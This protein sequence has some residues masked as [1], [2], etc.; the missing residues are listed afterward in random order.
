MS[1][2]NPPQIIFK[3]VPNAQSIKLRVRS[4]QLIQISYPKRT[5]QKAAQ[6]FLEKHQDFVV[7]RIA[8]I[9]VEKLAFFNRSSSA[10]NCGQLYFE[11]STS[12]RVAQIN[13][14]AE[15]LHILLPEQLDLTQVNHL[16]VQLIAPLKQLAKE[17]LTKRMLAHAQQNGYAIE[18]V[19]TKLMRSRWGSCSI[20]KNINLSA[21]LLLLPPTLQDYVMLHELAHLNEMNHSAAFWKHLSTLCPEALRLDHLLNRTQPPLKHYIEAQ[22]Q[23]Q[24]LMP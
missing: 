10:F 7:E 24:A 15:S 23:Y 18:Q 3:A 9:K 11:R 1:S 12:T 22:L 6:R 16:L 8:S 17:V 21:Y 2:A 20:R 14:A 4:E 19:R 5:S 13:K